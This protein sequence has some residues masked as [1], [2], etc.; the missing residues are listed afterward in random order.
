MAFDKGGYT[1]ETKTVSTDDGDKKVTYRLCKTGSSPPAPA[2]GAPPPALLAASGDSPLYDAPLRELGAADAS[3]AVFAGGGWCP[4][5]DLEHAD[6][7]YEWMYG[8]SA[9]STGEVV[10]QTVSKQVSAAFSDYQ[11]SLRLRGSRASAPSPR[12]ITTTTC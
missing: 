3:D 1:T 5:A 8:G 12:A 9:L 10:D 11:A 6:M 4:I 7:A 2:P